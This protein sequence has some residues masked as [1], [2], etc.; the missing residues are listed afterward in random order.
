MTNASLQ[1]PHWLPCAWCDYWV[2]VTVTWEYDG[3][4]KPREHGSPVWLSYSPQHQRELTE[5]VVYGATYLLLE[6]EWRAVYEVDL[7]QFIQVR[8]STKQRRVV[9]VRHTKDGIIWGGNWHREMTRS[10]HHELGSLC[11][12]CRIYTGTPMGAQHWWRTRANHITECAAVLVHARL[13]PRGCRNRELL[14]VMI[15]TFL[16]LPLKCQVP[17][18]V[19][20]MQRPLPCAYVAQHPSIRKSREMT[21][22]T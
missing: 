10:P 8:L 19:E 18:T 3:R 11:A 4:K 15:A 14:V 22:S 17:I 7:R 21:G 9:R 1:E 6:A 13:L 12:M 5:A 16:A 2:G 20:R